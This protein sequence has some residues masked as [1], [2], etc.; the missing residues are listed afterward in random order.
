[1][2]LLTFTTPTSETT[3]SFFTSANIGVYGFHPTYT[4]PYKVVNRGGMKIGIVSVICK[5]DAVDR[6]DESIMFEAPEKKLTELAPAFKKEK[7]DRWILIVHG[8]ET[9]TN[10][11]AKKFPMFNF[12]VTAD[13]PSEPPAEL[14]RVPGTKSQGVVEVGEK[15]KF[16]VVIGM[17]PGGK[18]RYQRVA[19]DSRYESSPDVS[20]LMKDYQTILKTLITSKGYR[21][22]LGL[23]PAKSP[24]HDVLGKFVG[25]RKCQSCHEDSYRVWARSKHATAWKSLTDTATPPRDFDPECIGCHVDGWEGLQHFPYADGFISEAETPHLMNVG[26]ESCHGPGEKHV[27]AELDADEPT[28]EK[29]RAAMRIGEGVKKT[30][31]SCHDADNSPDFDFDLYYPLVEHKENLDEE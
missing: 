30:C 17:F 26:C 5:S 13:T 22:G 10:D 25:T 24:R 3:P 19:L 14:R 15:G 27:A 8:T 11:L 21:N 7:C 9:E 18:M 1:H 4:A 2:F 28:Q 12:V 29:I 16:A 31:Y 6:R 23:T 20:L